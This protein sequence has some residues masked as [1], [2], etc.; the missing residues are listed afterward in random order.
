ME[1]VAEPYIRLRAI[2][3]LEKG[4]LVILAAGIGQPFVT[5]DYASVQ[6]A[7]ETRCSAMLVA[8]HGVDGVYSAEK[9]SFRPPLQDLEL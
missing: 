5:T 8:K 2:H 1:T 4:Y 3:N 7:I 6:R 9:G